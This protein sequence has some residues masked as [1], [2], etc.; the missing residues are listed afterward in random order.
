MRKFNSIKN[1]IYGVL[2]QVILIFS[3]FITNKIFINMLTVEYLG[4]N[5]LFTN[6]LSILNISEL[7][8]STAV[9]FSLYKELA[10]KDEKNISAIMNFYKRAYFIVGCIIL[11][12][13]LIILPFIQN[14]INTDTVIPY[15]RLIFILYLL[16]SIVSYWFYAYKSTILIADQKQYIVTNRQNLLSVLTNILQIIILICFKSFIFYVIIGVVFNI[17]KN[18]VIA[19]KVDKEYPFLKN[20]K[21]EKVGE[22]QK[23]ALYK[24]IIGVST[25][26]ISGTVLNSTDNIII[27]KFINIATTG[28][29]SSYLLIA[30]AISNIANTIF[31]AMTASIGNLNATETKEKNEFIFKCLSF[32]NFWVFGFCAICLLVLYNPFITIWLGNEYTFNIYIVILIVFNFLTDGLNQV[33]TIYKDACGV[34]WQGKFRPI[35]SATL[36]LVIS[37]ILVQYIGVAGVILGTILSRFLSTWWYD[38]RLIY[39]NVFEKNVVCYYKKYLKN[40]LIIILCGL[41]CYK[42][43]TIIVLN[44]EIFNFIVDCIIC[45]IIP[46]I[47]FYIFF[48]N[49][50]EFKYLSNIVKDFV[51][52]KLNFISKT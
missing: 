30:S 26:K 42:L 36:N 12:L 5:S 15:L 17:L 32:M 10:N 28:I 41:I 33:V 7:G 13:G 11:V 34:C 51:Q 44:N 45:I 22:K 1:I 35:V 21:K 43:S 25:Y 16:Q 38:S 14:F 23:K 3:K 6:I 9:S 8:I 24:Q 37:I 31:N 2:G 39:K 47:L 20:G 19:R 40:L 49:T 52:K 48:K 46:N 50:E 18:L 29:Y 4:V 27:S